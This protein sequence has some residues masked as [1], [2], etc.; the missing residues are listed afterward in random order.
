MVGHKYQMPYNISSIVIVVASAK[1]AC[2]KIGHRNT[3][4]Y[5]KPTDT[6]AY[7][8]QPK[9]MGVGWEK[10]KIPIQFRNNI[11]PFIEQWNFCTEIAI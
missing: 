6:T 3:N 7:N 5:K 1:E 11:K 9:Q 10:V 8:S 4:W 2:Q